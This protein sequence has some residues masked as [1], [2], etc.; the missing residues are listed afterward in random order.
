MTVN[1]YLSIFFVLFITGVSAC[2]KTSD[3]GTVEPPAKSADKEISAFELKKELN[4]ALDADVSGSITQ[5]TI[6]LQILAGTSTELKPTFTAKGTEVSVNGAVQKSGETVQDFASPVTYTVKAEDGSTKNYVVM[7]GSHMPMLFLTTDGGAAIGKEEYVKG[8]MKIQGTQAGVFGF[9]AAMRIRGRGNSTW[10]MEKKPYKIKLDEKASL[11]GLPSDKTWV[12]L[13]N[14][15]DKSMMR[16]E[17]AFELSRRM[18]LA[19]T[20]AS[21]YVE[22]TL[23]GRYDGVYELVEQIEMADH[24]V[25]VDKQGKNATSPAEITGGYLVEMDGFAWQEPFFIQTPREVKFSVKY[26]DIEEMSDAQKNYLNTYLTTFENALF[27][28]NFTDPVNGYRKYF[29]VDSYVNYYIVNE[30]MGNSDAFWST[31]F[32]KTRDGK[33]QAG[34][35]W[36]FDISVNNDSR[37]GDATQKLMLDAAH[38]PK[39]WVVRLME[40]P[41]FRKAVRDRWNAVK[42]GKVQTLPAYMQ[43]LQRQLNP[44]QAKNFKRWDILTKPVY[45]NYKVPGTYQGEVDFVRSTLQQRI[46]WLDGVINGSRFN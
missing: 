9:D 11:L 36:D 22:V 43:G 21:R 37:L 29:D 6:F 30:V 12:L 27:A 45:L 34:P 19:W 31:Y 26:P 4:P 35:V 44:V 7:I 13:A 42:A 39:K 46:Q 23:N 5:D 38:D 32:F 1:R 17:L 25:K 18:G 8:N 10:T 14:Y 20:P 15:A 40:D 16:N 28:T 33:L 41:A 3:P 24:K 2:K